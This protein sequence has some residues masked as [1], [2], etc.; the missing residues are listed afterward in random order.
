MNVQVN[1]LSFSDDYLVRTETPTPYTK[2]EWR[3]IEYP[4]FILP[5][6]ENSDYLKERL[7]EQSRRVPSWVKVG[8]PTMTAFFLGLTGMNLLYGGI[9]TSVAF[10]GPALISLFAS[11]KFLQS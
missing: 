9:G 2:P 6:P 5:E 8:F 7:E 1:S 3:G 4:V 11:K 10:L